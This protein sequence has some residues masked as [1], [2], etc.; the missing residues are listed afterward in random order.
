MR[1]VLVGEEDATEF[2]EMEWSNQGYAR[3]LE[4]RIARSATASRIT[5]LQKADRELVRRLMSRSLANVTMSTFRTEDFG[6][7]A[8][9]AM[10]AGVPSIATAWGGFSTTV[11]QGLT[12]WRVPVKLSGSSIEPDW[13]GAA[14]LLEH[15][16]LKPELRAQMSGHCLGMSRADHSAFLARCRLEQLLDQVAGGGAKNW[17]PIHLA[18]VLSEDVL[19][20]RRAISARQAEGNSGA[21]ARRGL[22]LKNES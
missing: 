13:R 20:F 4:E 5:W 9:E 8:V 21:S 2:P 19:S 15:L 12:G 22:F 11:V 1:C 3:T 14:D 7:T 17:A 6:F 18:D 16:L 10:W